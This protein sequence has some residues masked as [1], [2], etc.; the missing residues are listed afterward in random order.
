MISLERELQRELTRL[1]CPLVGP[2]EQRAVVHGEIFERLIAQFNTYR[3]LLT[4]IKM[5]YELLI[6][7]LKH[8][9]NLKSMEPLKPPEFPA[10]SMARTASIN[11]VASLDQTIVLELRDEI[12]SL[13]LDLQAKTK[14]IEQ[15]TR[16]LKEESDK[17]RLKE[18]SCQMMAQEVSYLRSQQDMTALQDA[19]AQGSLAKIRV[20]ALETTLRK[21]KEEM[22]QKETKYL[23]SI[24]ESQYLTLKT[25]YEE[26]CAKLDHISDEHARL[27]ESHQV[28]RSTLEEQQMLR[29]V[30]EER[31][32]ARTPR[33]DWSRCVALFEQQRDVEPWDDQTHSMSSDEKLEVLVDSYYAI[34]NKG[35]TRRRAEVLF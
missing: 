13:K 32:A 14:Q 4:A 18:E 30:F 1:Q 7:K 5:E 12:A 6:K 34:L 29:D 23:Q 27:L 3:P 21:T 9:L 35:R 17:R 28:L 20:E 11:D 10:P 22:A 16:M 33:P 31:A 26:A 25:Q 8:D 19:I 15:L 24:P 2:D